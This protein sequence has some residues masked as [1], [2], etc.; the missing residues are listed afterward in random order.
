MRPGISGS[1]ALMRAS[2]TAAPLPA[3]WRRCAGRTGSSTPSP[4]FAGPEAVL[5][6]LAR[7]TH[8]VAIS[9]RR[10]IALDEAG[11]PFRHQDFRREGGARYRTMR[12][13]T[14]G[15]IRRFLL[16]V[17]PHIGRGSCWGRR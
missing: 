17:P 14:A 7:Y 13:E 11:L 12:L 3:S 1:S 6:Y 10:L 16:P 2:V 4:P 9:N 5:A 15:L 8:R